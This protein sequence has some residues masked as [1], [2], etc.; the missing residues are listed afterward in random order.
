[1]NTNVTDRLREIRIG[2]DR[3]S[4]A[5]R[6][7]R[8]RYD[9][10]VADLRSKQVVAGA[11]RQSL[12]YLNTRVGLPL[13]GM[14]VGAVIVDRASLSEESFAR[15][16]AWADD[17]LARRIVAIG[18]LGQ[19][20]PRDSPGHGWRHWPWTPE[21]IQDVHETLGQRPPCGTLSTNVLLGS[22]ATSIGVA[23]YRADH[24][25]PHLRSVLDGLATAKR[26]LGLGDFPRPVADAAR[27]F[28]LLQGIW[29][30]VRLQDA[31]AVNMGHGLTAAGLAR[32]ISSQELDARNGPWAMY[33]ETAWPDLRRGLLESYR[34]LAEQ[35][36]KWD[37]L[38]D[39]IEWAYDARPGAVVVRVRSRAAKLAV[40]EELAG[41]LGI[42][43][44]ELVA[45][46][47][48]VSIHTYAERLEWN[49]NAGIAL[50]PTVPTGRQLPT[51]F[52]GECAQQVV[53]AAPGEDDRLAQMVDIAQRRWFSASRSSAEHLGMTLPNLSTNSRRVRRVYGPVD[54]SERIDGPKPPSRHAG[55]GMAALL[56]D[57]DEIL[58]H[59]G[60][61]GVSRSQDRVLAR[62]VLTEPEGNLIWLR[63]DRPID[64]IVGRRVA[65]A[66]VD[67]L[68]PGAKILVN[69]GDSRDRLFG[70]L[71]NAAHQRADVAV[72]DALLQVFR[73]SVFTLH[74]ELGSWPEVHRRLRSLGSSVSSP[75]T[76][77]NWA[78]GQVIAPE[79]PHDIN[80][81]GILAGETRLTSN[82][83][84]L[85]LA[86]IAQ[87]I[88]TM[89]S[90][91]GRT[92]VS[93]IS[94]S[95]RGIRGPAT[96]RLEDLYG[97]IDVAEI[98]EEFEMVVVRELG[99]EESVPRAMVERWA[100]AARRRVS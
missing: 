19:E 10:K 64:V 23:S 27:L 43:S 100:V 60:R 47:G 54:L 65:V 84:W 81:V 15:V 73:S 38:L 12:L 34:L 74:A 52:S 33:R 62:R 72:F 91:L 17:H 6:V 16:L 61:S 4:D 66:S 95:S 87:Q 86:R 82:K 53:A 2:R 49:P 24:L 45:G 51:L 77:S 28:S 37:L 8:V 39:L 48:S 36:P 96:S 90:E 93:A 67:V 63:S 88:R 59:V 68:V 75:Q 55:P 13:I 35:N 78:T 32:S 92:L 5:L 58:M 99:T 22:R 50:H 26:V 98:L 79:D 80:R 83:H 89:H 94:E 57:V 76:V 7:H 71:V 9:G 18:D 56:A 25:E 11:L 21:L 30:P 14:R 44:T 29:V 69:R 42:P 70:R 41:A 20:P 85:R 1:M 31:W 46:T 3:L 97:G 40:A